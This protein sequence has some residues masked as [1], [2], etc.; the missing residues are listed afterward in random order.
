MSRLHRYLWL[1]ALASLLG[2]LLPLLSGLLAGAHG[3]LP[4]LLDLASHWQWLFLAGLMLAV[5]LGAWFDRRWL[6]PLLAV[7]LPWLTAAPELPAGT[8]GS[9]LRVA[10]ANVYLNSTDIAPLATWLE[11]ARPDL[12]VLLEVSPQYASALQQLPG[13][14]HR[15]LH[16]DG[17][18]FGI[19][20][21]S[22][23]PLLHTQVNEDEQGIAHLRAQLR[24]HGCSIALSA[25][26]PMP[27]LSPD[28]HTRRDTRLRELLQG[29]GQRPALLA[30]DLNATPWSSA[31]AGLDQIGWRRASGLAPTWPSLGAGL[32]GIPIDHV[33]ASRHWRLLGHERGPHIGSDH[34]PV[35]ARLA[36]SNCQNDE[37]PDTAGASGDI[38]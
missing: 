1:L 9:E 2:L 13:Y 26:H 12:L 22:Q 11:Q 17:S 29:T 16:P 4:W 33:L 8:G 36:L 31:F 32:M 10:S 27:P 5:L 19:A 20:L 23:L 30:G 24:H 35:L 37:A 3:T 28:Y 15:L 7:P 18:P 34:F 14:P 6:L 38:R 25:F 21:L